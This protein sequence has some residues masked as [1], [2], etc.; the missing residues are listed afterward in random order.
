M[1]FEKSQLDSSQLQASDIQLG[2]NT[3]TC[4]R[5]GNR[6]PDGTAHRGGPRAQCKA[7][8][9]QDE[10][11]QRNALM[12]KK[13]EAD[14]K[15]R[16]EELNQTMLEMKQQIDLQEAKLGA[17]D[18]AATE[19]R[20]Q[21]DRSEFIHLCLNNP[22]TREIGE[23]CCKDMRIKGEINFEHI[24]KVWTGA[25]RNNKGY[26]ILGN[27]DANVLYEVQGSAFYGCG[28]GGVG[29][30]IKLPTS[31][32]RVDTRAFSATSLQE[33]EI[34]HNIAS[35]GSD[36]FRD[37]RLLE[38]VIIGEGVLNLGLGFFR[39]CP[40]I[41]NVSFPSSLITI[42]DSCFRGFYGGGN[43]RRQNAQIVPKD[44]ILNSISFNNGLQ[45]IGD[46]AFYNNFELTEI[47]IPA[48]VT[49]IGAFAFSAE[50]PQKKIT[51]VV[52]EGGPDLEIGAGA[53]RNLKNLT[54]LTISDCKT[55]GIE[56]FAKCSIESDLSFGAN[57]EV[58]GPS[59]FSQ[60]IKTGSVSYLFETI[61][62][63]SAF[64]KCELNQNTV[65][66]SISF[67]NQA[68]L[69]CR[70]NNSGTLNI[71]CGGNVG[72]EAFK[73][74]SLAYPSIVLGCNA[75]IIDNYVQGLGADCF[76]FSGK[77]ASYS[78][79]SVEF[80]QGSLNGHPLEG[81][82]IALNFAD[83][84]PLSSQIY[85]LEGLDPQIYTQ[86]VTVQ[87]YYDISQLAW[88][89]S[90][91]TGTEFLLDGLF[92]LAPDPENLILQ[93]DSRVHYY[94][95]SQI[96]NADWTDMV[97]ANGGSATI[98]IAGRGRRVYKPSLDIKFEAEANWEEYL[99]SDFVTKTGFNGIILN[100]VI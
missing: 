22:A 93:E 62:G 2:S 78:A 94:Y 40:K 29:G 1:P 9:I 77:G 37:N 96:K 73:N 90:V 99:N 52:I 82:L 75:P 89:V 16:A 61:I 85:T 14:T 46:Y 8:A 70:F 35:Q 33:V 12:W 79:L 28:L 6:L 97:D 25:F 49:E 48:S 19:A 81:E 32:S 26:I 43:V 27:L 87:A 15:R 86:P 5:I 88:F 42:G 69:E 11:N 7:C 66:N 23:D 91:E 63:Q 30:S 44:N 24:E 60:G 56:A 31:L 100:P 67:G 21:V 17:Q 54:S 76:A 50:V 51:S 80:P 53:F 18:I 98:K 10:V 72:A 83:N 47:T 74:I 64:Y 68:F 59:A 84:S 3:P 41:Q 57:T 13:M 36:I 55:V 38:R 95:A 71:S 45:R 65:S 20:Y 92:K 39:E 58:I 4:D 34:N